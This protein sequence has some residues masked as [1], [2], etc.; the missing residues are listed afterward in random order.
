MQAVLG[1]LVLP[2]SLRYPQC[3]VAYLV[4]N[5]RIKAV[6]RFGVRKFNFCCSDCQAFVLLMA[7]HYGNEHSLFHEIVRGFL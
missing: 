7:F 4:H 1:T 3:L 2:L 6:A 5:V